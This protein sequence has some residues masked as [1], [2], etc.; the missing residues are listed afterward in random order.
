MPGNYNNVFLTELFHEQSSRWATIARRH[1]THIYDITSAFI[2]K[3]LEHVVKE[4]HVYSEMYKTISR[5]FCES[6]EAALAE[7]DKLHG[8]ESIQPITYNHYY[9][10]NI[11]KARQDMTKKAIAQAVRG[12]SSDWDGV[13][14]VSNTHD[15]RLRLLT[16]LQNHITVDMEQE[17]CNEGKTSLQAYYKVSSN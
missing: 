8:D 6:F 1:V 3:A 9:T 7:L 17:A 13:L 10:D 5:R 12:A 15:D 2:K 14:H 11:Q 16:T 4:K